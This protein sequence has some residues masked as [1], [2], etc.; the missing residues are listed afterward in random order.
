VKNMAGPTVNNY[1]EAAR[2]N[3]ETAAAAGSVKSTLKG[4][5][6]ALAGSAAVL[7]LAPEPI[8]TKTGAVICGAAAL[9]TGAGSLIAGVVEGAANTQGNAYASKDPDNVR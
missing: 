4:W 9:I 5:T 7:A 1:S 6:A 8:A 2:S 3:Y